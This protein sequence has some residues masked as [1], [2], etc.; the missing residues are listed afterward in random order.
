MQ[1]KENR[2]LLT[3]YRAYWDVND[4][5]GRVVLIADGAS[6]VH[7]QL[8]DAEEFQAVVELLRNESPLYF[9]RQRLFIQTDAEPIGEAE[10]LTR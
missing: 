4:H 6:R 5:R 2:H 3:G 1:L 8:H 10:P 9:D 7:L